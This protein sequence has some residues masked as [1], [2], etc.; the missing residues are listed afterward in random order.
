MSY[1]KIQTEGEMP[2]YIK[3]LLVKMDFVGYVPPGQKMCTRAKTY[4][5][6]EYWT[7]RPIRWINGEGSDTT[8]LY[9]DRIITKIC[10]A[11]NEFSSTTSKMR[12]TLIDKAKI[13]RQGLVNL[14]A[15]Y[16]ENADASSKLRTCL[17]VLDIKIPENK[18]SHD[19]S[20][21]LAIKEHDFSDDGSLDDPSDLQDLSPVS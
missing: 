20:T 17:E 9:V 21:D 19:F 14:V 10:E 13:F 5:D 18:R 15:T 7:T 16:Q 8:C 3:D 6:P 12:K 4:V 1:S 2:T 11:L